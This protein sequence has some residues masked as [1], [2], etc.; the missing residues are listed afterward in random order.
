M[1]CACIVINPTGSI[2]LNKSH[3]ILLPRRCTRLYVDRATIS[4]RKAQPHQLPTYLGTYLHVSS[5][6]FRRALSCH[7]SSRLLQHNKCIY[8]RRTTS[9]LMARAGRSR[10]AMVEIGAIRPPEP[11]SDPI[12]ETMQWN[13][14]R[15]MH[16]S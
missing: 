9:R 6:N 12:Q 13:R 16:R 11:S 4:A 8:R 2:P 10:Q 5:H 1:T 7:N 15:K 14:R 3:W